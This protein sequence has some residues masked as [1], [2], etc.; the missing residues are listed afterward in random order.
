MPPDSIHVIFLSERGTYAAK[1]FIQSRCVVNETIESNI[2]P[3]DAMMWINFE[4]LHFEQENWAVIVNIAARLV[5]SRMCPLRNC[6]I[7]NEFSAVGE[8]EGTQH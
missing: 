4:P 6:S 5:C 7:G 3:G 1:L 8:L 2:R